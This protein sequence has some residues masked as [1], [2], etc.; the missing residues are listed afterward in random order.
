MSELPPQ[1][2]TYRSRR[3]RGRY[4]LAI[5][6][7]SIGIVAFTAL[8]IVPIHQSNQ[9]GFAFSTGGVPVTSFNNSDTQSLCPSGAHVGV[10]LWSQGLELTFRI[11]AANGS[12]IWTS[13]AGN[14]STTF[15]VASCG[16]FQFTAFGSG[17]GNYSVAGTIAF[18]API[19]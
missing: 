12:L 5:V 8:A 1:P 15:S 3:L 10:S 18:T 13:S 6:I 17:N 7:G 4:V 2:P 19:L 9:F 14:N 16:D 11:T